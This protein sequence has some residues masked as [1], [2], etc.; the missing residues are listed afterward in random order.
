MNLYFTSE[1][2]NCLDLFIIINGSKNVFKL[3][4]QWQRSIPNENTKQPS[5]FSF[6]TQCKTWSFLVVFLQRTAKKCTTIYNA[7]AQPLF[8]SLKPRPNDR[9][10]STQHIPT[11]L[12]QHLQA[13]A[14]TI[15]TFQRNILQHFRAQHVAC[16]WFPCCDMGIENLTSAH[17]RV[18]HCFTNLAKR[19]Q[20]HTTSKIAA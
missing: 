3:N 14:K 13:S 17:A 4:M 19:P 11:L 20:H 7:R 5:S 18:Q 2:C 15:G 8:R 16:I 10:I 12:A 9:N 1:I 6:L